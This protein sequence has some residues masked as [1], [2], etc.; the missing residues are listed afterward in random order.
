MALAECLIMIVHAQR[1]VIPARTV[2]LDLSAMSQYRARVHIQFT[3]GVK[4]AEKKKFADTSLTIDGLC[5]TTRISS[6]CSI[7]T[8]MLRHVGASRQSSIYLSTFT[9]IMIGHLLL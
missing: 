3:D 9:R 4:M 2:T 7:A 5:L 6:V 8:S 1:V